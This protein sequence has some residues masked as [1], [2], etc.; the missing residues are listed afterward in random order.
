MRL[1]S[2]QRINWLSVSDRVWHDVFNNRV[3]KRN[4][5]PLPMELDNTRYT[6]VSFIFVQ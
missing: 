1:A 3:R 5:I 6:L 2:C 4:F